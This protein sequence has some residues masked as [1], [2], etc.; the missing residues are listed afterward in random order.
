MM[1]MMIICVLGHML[2]LEL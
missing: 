1:N 2:W